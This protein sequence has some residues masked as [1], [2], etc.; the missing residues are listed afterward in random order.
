MALKVWRNRLSRSSRMATARPKVDRRWLCE[1]LEERVAL[2]GLT[3]VVTSLQD[4][5][6]PAGTTSLRQ[7]ITQ[8]D[9]NPE[10]IINFDAGLF[11]S[12]PESITLGSALPTVTANM[13]INGPG[14]G[15]LTIDG[16]GSSSDFTVLTV[17]TNTT[18]M[19]SG[20]TISQ[21]NVN[22][23]TAGAAIDNSGTLNLSDVTL[24]GNSAASGEGGGIFNHSGTLSLADSTLSGNSAG[25]S[26]GG[27]RTDDGSVTLTRTV[28]SHN[29]ANKDGGGIYNNG[30]KLVLTD[31]TISG[32][33]AQDKGG[34]IFS[35][36]NALTLTGCDIFGNSA[37]NDGGGVM[38]ESTMTITDSTIS[39]NTAG[40]NGGGIKTLLSQSFMMNS[41]ISGNSAT[42]GGGLYVWLGRITATNTT[43]AQN[44]ANYGGGIDNEGNVTLVNST[45][46][47]NRSF[48]VPGGGVYNN[49]VFTTYNSLIAGNTRGGGPTAPS[50]VYGIVE[51]A[52][53]N[54]LIGAADGLTGIQNGAQ[55]NLI[56]TVASPI[57]AKLGDF[58][59]NGGPTSTFALLAGSPA[60]DA[61]SASITGVSVP[62]IDQ[63][64][65]SRGPAG[66]NAGSAPDIGAFEAT[67]SYVVTSPVDTGDDVGT[68]R[69][70][71][72]WANQNLNANP[73]NIPSPVSNTISFDTTGP[74]SPP[75]YLYLTTTLEL[76]NKTTPITI[77][78]PTG[79]LVLS[80]IRGASTFSIFAIDQGVNASLSNLALENGNAVV[81]GAITNSGNLAVTD[82]VLSGNTA[83]DG[84]AIYNHGHLTLTRTTVQGNSSKYGGGGIVNYPASS[85]LTVINSLIAN[86]KSGAGG[87]GISNSGILVIR[88]STI[89]GNYSADN[90]GGIESGTQLEISNST[91]TG[92]AAADHAG[93]LWLSGPSTLT[94]TTLFGNTSNYGGGLLL[95][96]APVTLTNTTIT[97]NR[98]VRSPSGGISNLGGTLKLFNT[99]IAGNFTGT[100]VSIAVGTLTGSGTGRSPGDIQGAVDA[101]STSNLIG[102]GDNLTGITDGSQGNLIGTQ[103]SPI[104]A[105]LGSLGSNGGPTATAIP[106][107]GS[108]AIN[109]GNNADAID[110][111]TGQ[112]LQY[113]QRGVGYPRIIGGHVD[114]GALEVQAVSTNLGV[115]DAV[116]TYGGTTSLSA[117]L[118]AG[119]LPVA[120]QTVVFQVG[121]QVLGSAKTD[122]QGHAT[123]DSVSLDA[124]SAGT[125]HLTANFAG[126]SSYLASSAVSQLVVQ[127]AS[128]TLL[129]TPEFK[130]YGAALPTLGY[131]V[132]GFVHG[133]TPA[134][135]SGSPVLSTNA[136]SLSHVSG[137]PYVIQVSAGTLSAMNYVITTLVS[138]TLSIVPA[139]L[140]I[141]A[142]DA[143]VVVNQPFPTFTATYAG[144]VAGDTQASLTSAVSFTTNATKGSGVGSY[145]IMPGG[146][147]DS[148]YSIQYVPGKLSIS[149]VALQPDPS[150]PGQSILE[151]GG[152]SGNN[153]I[154]FLHP[155]GAKRYVEAKLNGAVLGVY[156]TADLSQ[157]WA[158]GGPAANKITVAPSI[159]LPTL[160][161]GGNGPNLIKGGGGNNVL[162]GG[163]SSNL[164]VAGTQRDVLIGGGG[165]NLLR[166]GGGGDILVRGTTVY[167]QNVDALDA[168]LAEWSST[169]DY[170]TRSLNVQGSGAN[171]SFAVRLNQNY[172]LITSGP[173][174]TVQLNPSA[175]T[176]VPK[177]GP[178]LVL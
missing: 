117:T 134:V 79:I 154:Q 75:H 27:I 1:A 158:F 26:G 116:G 132:T 14:S 37:G 130:R 6:N 146:A 73:A 67:S 21:A 5:S 105:L 35:Y 176:V 153:L 136:T 165:P 162:V 157:I 112:A 11:S 15:V 64:G 155:G 86:N 45:L 44:N 102:D 124:L 152:T 78:G 19:V 29:S 141:T 60:I 70:A 163:P 138:S 174:A 178:N 52:S 104:D 41:T 129:A 66:L 127:K 94:N 120:G 12:G 83:L 82:S 43:F 149:Q 96:H 85:T 128:L 69:S 171:P 46:S 84:G 25:D 166:A 164:L 59:D 170:L 68:L 137:S 31:S 39:E 144:F 3:I 91:I 156:A 88:D 61:A 81:G 118:T 50:D 89:S 99:L 51:P 65:G 20:L 101:S 142:N 161:L 47:S 172:F 38:N 80:A 76:S 168:I 139:P 160:L 145:T 175:N 22:S 72:S 40:G 10:S 2:S 103:A 54:N 119:G 34:G 77:N 28:V 36:N 30:G 32:N 87:G 18:A 33:A 150:H 108:P 74:L 169:H 58:G 173:N 110:P 24:S 7:A 71:V 13:T 135:L 159:K 100:A 92:N 113:D 125:Y 42:H 114:I 97:S 107:P 148:D 151:V 111:N 143:S 109:A 121:S 62:V 9:L 177:L 55:G 48:N 56:G 106:L 93:G 167:D 8:A 122:S 115:K 23:K 140:T 90:G 53:S 16:G 49:N 133:D 131:T 4:G 57:D 98:A 147:A 126:G 95:Y 17:A 63:R 123:L